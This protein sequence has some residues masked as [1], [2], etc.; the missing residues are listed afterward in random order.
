MANFHV[1]WSSAG[2]DHA[3]AWLSLDLPGAPPCS[4]AGPARLAL[5]EPAADRSLAR[6]ALG[7]AASPGGVLHSLGPACALVCFVDP[8]PLRLTA[9]AQ[10][11]VRHYFRLADATVKP[12]APTPTPFHCLA[13]DCY[14]AVMLRAAGLA[15][16]AP[17]GANEASTAIARF[18]H[19]RDY[20]NADKLA[21]T[22]LGHLAD[23]GA[24][25]AGVMVI[26]AR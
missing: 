20:F 26:E 25:S 9:A 15:D 23:L 7:A 14:V 12:L 22:L 4:L 1:A 6:S 8:A 17:G 18:I 19:L 3:D 13:G 5:L 24:T 21:R 2:A 16:G 10:P 11:P